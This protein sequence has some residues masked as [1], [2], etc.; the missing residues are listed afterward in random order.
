MES[1]ANGVRNQILER[2]N[3]GNKLLNIIAKQNAS[4]FLKISTEFTK[5]CL[6]CLGIRCPISK[7][8]G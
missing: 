6:Q 1:Q 3:L 4:H 5:L 7:A 8:G 2:G